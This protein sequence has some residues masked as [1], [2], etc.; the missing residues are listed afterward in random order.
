MLL[1]HLCIPQ[2]TEHSDLHIADIQQIFVERIL[3][4]MQNRC[5][6]W[7]LHSQNL[8]FSGTDKINKRPF[9]E[10]YV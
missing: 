10:Q 9:T 7:S 4:G 6:T 3:R 1:T 8:Y 5:K 2:S